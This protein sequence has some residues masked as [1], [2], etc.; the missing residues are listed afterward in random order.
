[1]VDLFSDQLYKHT[2]DNNPTMKLRQ[3]N[4]SLMKPASKA[5]VR[6]AFTLI[7]LLVVIAIIAILAA[8]LLP[9][10]S[11]AKLKATEANCQSN[12]RQLIEAFTMY[13]GDSRD[14]M[15]ASEY[16]SIDY[17]GSG[18]YIYTD[19][20]TGT[21]QSAAEQSVATMLIKTCP[22]YSYV[23]NYKAFH[24]PSDMRG[25][26]EVG[27][28]WAYVS[29]SKA[30]GMG[31]EDSSSYWG[32]QIP[33]EWLSS[34]TPTSQSFVFIEEADPRGYNE[35][36]WVVDQSTGVGN[37]GWVDNFA[38]FHSIVS[39]FAFADGHVVG[40]AWKNRQLITAEQEVAQ[41]NF[42]GYYAPGGDAK[43]PDYVWIWYGYRFQNWAP[44]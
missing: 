16:G 43:D 39:T 9:T 41:G 18:F 1:V 6:S 11:R 28:G 14:K 23:P 37:S 4:K 20:P 38:I 8:M 42:N 25:N 44:L 40:H 13:A 7:E 2:Q 31:H 24:C 36:T 3:T 10:L 32:D 21:S 33:Y 12:Q 17:S 26:F 34:V 30:N 22:F 27:K 5:G 19:I 15:A 35:G 29:Y